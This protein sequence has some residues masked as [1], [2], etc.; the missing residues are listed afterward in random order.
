MT[1]TPVPPVATVIFALP[2]KETPWIVLAVWRV[3][4]VAM[5]VT[6]VYVSAALLDKTPVDAPV[7]TVARAD[8]DGPI[9]G[10]IVTLDDVFA[11]YAALKL[12][13]TVVA[14]APVLAADAAPRVPSPIV[15]LE[16]DAEVILPVASTAITGMAVEL[17]YVAAVTP[18]AARPV[19]TAAEP[20]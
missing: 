12:I 7:I 2:L 15:T 16:L 14:V 1:V 8:S 20:L 19:V 13:A 3:V 10:L 9:T 18:E 17:P 11:L 6:R 5:F 4:A